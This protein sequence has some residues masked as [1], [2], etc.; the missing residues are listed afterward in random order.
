MVSWSTNGLLKCGLVGGS[1]IEAK[2]ERSR[3]K[4]ATVNVMFMI[5]RHRGSIMGG[6]IGLNIVEC[7]IVMKN[8]VGAA[9]SN[10]STLST[11]DVDGKEKEL[12]RY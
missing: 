3:G 10:D 9:G 7:N 5:T 1:L 6:L 8:N 12:M 11:V 4:S 2:Y